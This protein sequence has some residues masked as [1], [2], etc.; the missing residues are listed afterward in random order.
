[1]LSAL[2]MTAMLPRRW[3][4]PAQLTLAV[5]ELVVVLGPYRLSPVD[6]QPVLAR[7]EPLRAYQRVVVLGETGVVAARLGPA[8]QVTHPGGFSSLLNRNYALLL[9]GAEPIA[10]LRIDRAANPALPLLGVEAAFDE[11]LQQL[12]YPGLPGP[13]VWVARCAWPG[14]ALQVREPNFPRD[15]CVTRAETLEPDPVQPPGP[16]TLLQAGPGWMLAEAEGPGWL[17]TI[18]PWYPGWTARVDDETAEVTVLDGALAGV[19]LADGTHRVRLQYRPAGLE[20]GI[21]LSAAVAAIL[22]AWT[23]VR[24]AQ[25]RP[26]ATLAKWASRGRRPPR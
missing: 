25:S 6:L 18:H 24:A 2:A 1:M 8:I 12:A 16:A 9:T 10:T 3:R 21:A 23:A 7:L 13:P 4:G 14:G 11:H 20:L 26:F 15:R 5:A 17:V 19:A 22:V